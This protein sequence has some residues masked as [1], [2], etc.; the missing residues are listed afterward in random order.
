MG[1]G[2]PLSSDRVSLASHDGSFGFVCTILRCSSFASLWYHGAYQNET[3][4]RRKKQLRATSGHVVRQRASPVT[5]SY[6][7]TPSAHKSTACPH[8]LG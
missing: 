8:D 3:P 5:I 7:N 2:R 6:S 4:R 1:C